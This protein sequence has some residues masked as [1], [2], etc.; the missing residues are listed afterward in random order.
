M[1][2]STGLGFSPAPPSPTYLPGVDS[3]NFTESPDVVASPP[4]EKAGGG[5]V[6]F[7]A[8]APPSYVP[9]LPP[10]PEAPG[11]PA[12][13]ASESSESESEE[14]SESDP[15]DPPVDP[16]ESLRMSGQMAAG[17][18]EAAAAS[19]KHGEVSL[20]LVATK[21]PGHSVSQDGSSVAKVS[22]T[23]ALVLPEPMAPPP[24]QNAHAIETTSAQSGL[25]SST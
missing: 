15:D 4:L 23:R 16:N 9:S 7:V 20:D 2:K 25:K 22:P 19:G 21:P 13:D 3:E 1:H 12:R 14:E 11:P 8:V 18:I 24:K 10:H 6:A 5:T 17:R